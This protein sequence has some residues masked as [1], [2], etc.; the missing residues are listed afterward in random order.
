MAAQ[1]CVTLVHTT[2]YAHTQTPS[3]WKQI[4]SELKQKHSGMPVALSNH[5]HDCQIHEG[6][7]GICLVFE[8]I[9]ARAT[10]F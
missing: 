9:V 8:Y 1:S 6:L 2:S 10:Q 3:K 5:R 7:Y 4:S